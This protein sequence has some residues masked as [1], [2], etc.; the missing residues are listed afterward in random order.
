[1]EFDPIGKY[2]M[3]IVE[4]VWT[5]RVA[6]YLDLFHGSQV[7]VGFFPKALKLVSEDDNFI[8]H[9]N[10][11]PIGEVQKLVDLRLDLNDV[12]LKI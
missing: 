1:V 2:A 10:A 3:D 6:C 4:G 5:F 7:R 12:A 8:G 9:V 11:S